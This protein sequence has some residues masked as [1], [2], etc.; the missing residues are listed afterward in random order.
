[1]ERSGRE[2]ETKERLASF[3]G[4]EDLGWHV[5]RLLRCEMRSYSSQDH[6]RV[7]VCSSV[8]VNRCS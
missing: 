1:M 7:L 6:I 4:L 3:Q 5:S 2:T 8:S